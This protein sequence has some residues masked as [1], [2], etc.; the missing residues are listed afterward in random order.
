ADLDATDPAQAEALSHHDSRR[1]RLRTTSPHP[2]SGYQCR[3]RLDLPRS[4][5]AHSLSDFRQSRLRL[6]PAPFPR[7]RALKLSRQ[8]VAG[9]PIARKS[10]GQVEVEALA[11]GRRRSSWCRYELALG[12]GP[13][14]GVSLGVL[15]GLGLGEGD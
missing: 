12:V 15:L 6:D 3:S 9:R 10:Q 5:T 8:A 2:P 11:G 13:A 14:A 1:M 4:T 7:F